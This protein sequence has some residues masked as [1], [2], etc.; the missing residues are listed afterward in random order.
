M[1]ARAQCLCG[2]VAWEVE[3]PLQLVHECHCRYC[4][5]SH[6]TGSAAFAAVPNERF[7][8]LRGEADIHH[9]QSSPE[10]RRCF[11]G[12]CGSQVPGGD[13]FQGMTFLPIGALEGDFEAV[14]DG[15]IFVASKQP[16]DAISDGKPVFDTWPAGV[17]NA[18]QS[19]LA[20]SAATPGRIGGSCLCGKL[21]WEYQGKPV[22]ARRCHCLRC[23][24]ARAHTHAANAMVPKAALRWTA[25][26]D[27]VQSFKLPEAERFTQAFCPTCGSK[28]PWYIALRD[29]WVVPMGNLDDDPGVAPG[30]H[31]FVG[32]KAHW[33]A[34]TDGVP[35][36]DAYP[37]D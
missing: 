19:D 12:R 5:K 27:H 21:A 25:G 9:Y 13:A 6:G 33:E 34:I 11:C 3:P 1:T 17:D 31:I 22:L 29:A 2:D 24:R 20:R 26:E 14:S 35:Q 16:W 37:P 8:W 10:M 7:R 23:R 28:A 4:Q 36:H 32:S 18:V 30:E 15:H